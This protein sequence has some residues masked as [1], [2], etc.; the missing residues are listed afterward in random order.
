M[1]I[2][3]GALFGMLF[4]VLMKLGNPANMG[5]CAICFTRDIAGAIGLH[6]IEK[7][8][9]IRPEIVGFIIGASV[10][11]LAFGEL[12]AQGGSSTMLRFLIAVFV[13]I[14]ALVF[15]GCPIRMMG[16]LANGDPTA[17]MGVLGFSI[18]ILI[19]VVFLRA[20]FT[21]GRAH[22][23]NRING[24]IIPAIALLLLILLLAKPS[25]IGLYP[26]GHAP[27]LISLAAGLGIGFL[28]QRSRFCFVGGLRDFIL[29]KDSHLFQGF[30]AFFV[31][32]LIANL[33]LGQFMPGAHPIAHTNHLASLLAMV[34]VG[35]GSVLL[36]GCPFRQII[37]SGQG[38][39][40]SG[41]SV[42]GFLVGAA[43]SHNF[44]LAGSP[45]GVPI[46][47]MV[48]I[49]GGIVILLVIGFSNL[50]R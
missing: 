30:A 41:V 35:F 38:N 45:K 16:R 31:F 28:A 36:G 21:L 9:Y 49:I 3:T 23:Q 48:A 11:S 6:S 29:I 44:I 22:Q 47:G 5:V 25:F 34:V 39:S 20:G 46:N 13:A 37:L 7:L 19:G 42:L 26:N 33:L 24:W 8:S 40:D 50:K 32:C 15:L 10:A 14:G 2:I 4:S 1:V 17:L 27:L 18:G 12:R 43:L